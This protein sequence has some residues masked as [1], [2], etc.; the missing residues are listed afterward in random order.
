MIYGYACGFPRGLDL[1]AQM[2]PLWAAGCEIITQ[3]TIGGPT[4][5]RPRLGRMIARLG[6]QG[7]LMVTSIDRP[8]GDLLQLVEIL[9]DLH[10]RGCGFRSLNEPAIDTT[11]RQARAVIGVLK[12]AA[13]WK[14]GFVVDRLADARAQARARG[15]KF[16]RR[17][18]LSAPQRAE[19][20]ARLSTGEPQR[21]VAQAFK[22][23]QATISRLRPIGGAK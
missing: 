5:D 18:K 23:S 10:Q 4:A 1:T 21:S 15:V 11:G 16:G 6:P 20:L 9:D 22:V 17:V 3:E 13:L 7:V 19:A 8:A 14:Q 2:D 12:V